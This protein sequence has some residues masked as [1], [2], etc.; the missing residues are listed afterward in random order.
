MQ[1][2]ALGSL[3]VSTLTVTGQ[4]KFNNRNCLETATDGTCV[5]SMPEN[6]S[7]FQ[8]YNTNLINTGGVF[9]Y[10]GGP[11]CMPYPG[12]GNFNSCVGPFGMSGN[13][14]TIAENN[15][16]MGYAACGAIRAGFY[17]N[18]MGGSAGNLLRDGNYNTLVGAYAGERITDQNGNTN[19]GF[20]SGRYNTAG[21]FTASVG[22]DAGNGTTTLNANTGG[23]NNVYLGP[24][25]GQDVPSATVLSN[26]IAIGNSALVHKSNQAQIGGQPD[27]G[28]QVEVLASSYTAQSGWIQLGA[29]TKA[30]LGAMTPTAVG[31]QYYCSDCTTDSVA[32]STGTTRGGF[33]R[34]TSKTTF[35]S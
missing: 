5:F 20:E 22:F 27:T 1:N 11:T 19:I 32:V 21:E 15:N 9:N 8:G 13:V 10:S 17:N 34:A 12:G 14:I 35:P 33:G 26:V 2:D 18:C 31:Q 28:T 3:S 29:H 25:T 24:K 6:N 4:I 30:E 7:M 23:S 16:S